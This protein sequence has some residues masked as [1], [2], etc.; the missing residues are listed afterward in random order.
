MAVPGRDARY[1]SGRSAE[2]AVGGRSRC[3]ATRKITGS[4]RSA[5][6]IDV[7]LRTPNWTSGAEPDARQNGLP[8]GQH[9]GK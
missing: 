9:M 7:A 3:C 2:A 1:A 8:V 5:G 4:M 6:K